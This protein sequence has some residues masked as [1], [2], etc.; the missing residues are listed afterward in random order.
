MK[1]IILLYIIFSFHKIVFAQNIAEFLHHRKAEVKMLDAYV[2]NT[3]QLSKSSVNTNNESSYVKDAEQYL[4]A[5]TPT[6]NNK[7]VGLKLVS[8]YKSLI[9]YHHLFVQTY[10]GIE[11]YQS[12]IK[13]NVNFSGKIISISNNLFDASQWFETNYTTTQAPLNPSQK[14]LWVFDGENLLPSISNNIVLQNGL[15]YNEIYHTSQ[16]KKIY[17]Q[18]THLGFDKKDTLVKSKIFNPDPISPL[19]AIYNSPWPNNAGRWVDSN[20][21]DYPI[22]NEQRQNIMLPVRI[23]GDTFLMENQYAISMDIQYPNFAVYKSTNPNFEV[24][25]ATSTFR[26]EMCLYHIFS[27]QKYLQT[28]GLKD[29]CNYQIQI[30]ANGHAD[31]NSNFSYGNQPNYILFGIGGV[32]DAEDADVINHEYTHACIYSAAPNTVDPSNPGDRLALEEGTCDF[33][34]AQFS[35]MKYQFNWQWFA[36]W[37]GYPWTNNVNGGRNTGTKK[38]YPKDLINNNFYSNSEIWSAFLNDVATKIGSDTTIKILFTAVSSL[39]INTSMPEAAQL[40]LIADSILYN[41]EHNAAIEK[42]M[43]VHGFMKSAGTV[44]A[45]LDNDY[46]LYNTHN[47]SLNKGNAELVLH[48]AKINTIKIYTS[49]GQ[50][51]NT[52]LVNDYNIKLNADEFLSGLYFIDVLDNANKVLR[53]KLIKY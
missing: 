12:S 1:K 11:V 34:A 46:T 47:F 20:K 53:V 10:K 37:D 40:L 51:Y 44:N 29:I 5:N 2:S 18:A 32:P 45:I 17:T 52:I 43:L 7:F 26:E 22:L 49:T 33:M 42:L 13:I 25:R 24:T 3:E 21:I 41:K 38:V 23:D 39:D 28:I 36:N 4:L 27:Y 8:T 48:H 16:N 14:A 30:D 31:D 19:G 15:S 50:L 35:K 6:L 9:G